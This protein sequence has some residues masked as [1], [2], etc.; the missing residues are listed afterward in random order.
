MA[1]HLRQQIRERVGTLLTGLTTTGS[2]V[3]QSRIYPLQQSSLPGILIY[4]NEEESEYLSVG[5]TRLIESRLSLSIEAYCQGTS[6][7]DDTIDTISKEVQIAISG[8]RFL[9]GLAKEV[10]LSTTE[11]SFD[12]STEKPIGFISLIYVVSYHF[13]ENAPDV[14]K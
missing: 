8:D 9:N 10:M 12:G 1:N 2:N 5:D 11:I 7:F 3:F 4:T 13:D 14:A 6:N